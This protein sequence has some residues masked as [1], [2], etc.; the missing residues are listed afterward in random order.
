MTVSSMQFIASGKVLFTTLLILVYCAVATILY[1][2]LSK[3]T[4]SLQDTDLCGDFGDHY[5]S[6][7]EK[8]PNTQEGR[9][10]YPSTMGAVNA[11]ALS[12]LKD[13]TSHIAYFDRFFLDGYSPVW[14]DVEYGYHEHNG[15]V[16]HE[17]LSSDDPLLC[18]T[19]ATWLKNDGDE[20]TQYRYNFGNYLSHPDDIKFSIVF[21]TGAVNGNI[22]END[23]GD[24]IQF[25]G[26]FQLNVAS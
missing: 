3:I 19:T 11:G 22:I 8:W 7:R 2:P 25:N 17:N 10:L 9:P 21:A 23:E 4:G 15:E 6:D 26:F 12:I 24:S 5:L 13:E 20:A 18:G 16:F 14:G 1:K